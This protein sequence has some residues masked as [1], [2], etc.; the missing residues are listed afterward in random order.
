MR[1]SRQNRNPVAMNCTAS[2]ERFHTSDITVYN[3]KTEMAGQYD[4]QR[5]FRDSVMIAGIVTIIIAFIGL[6]GYT[7]DEVSRRSKE[8]AIRKVNGTNVKGIVMLFIKDMLIISVPSLIVGGIA[9][10]IVGN[11]WLSL[12]SEQVTLAPWLSV[13]CIMAITTI[14]V[15]VVILNCRRIAMSNPVDYLKSE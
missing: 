4:T 6:V 13:L 5:N 3:V 15:I 14:L 8:I 12:F 9:A 11:R 10:A 7:A 1:M 2:N